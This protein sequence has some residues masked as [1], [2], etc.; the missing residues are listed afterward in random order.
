MFKKIIYGFLSLEIA[1][2]LIALIYCV[3]FDS[4]DL[5]LFILASTILLISS[6]CYLT[7]LLIKNKNIRFNQFAIYLAINIAITIL[8]LILIGITPVTISFA[9][10]ILVG[11]IF[12]LIINIIFLIIISTRKKFITKDYIKVD[13]HKQLHKNKK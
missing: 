1:V 11:N 8:N 7:F 3:F 12:A 6:F 2:K 4:Y 10:V 13:Y 9:Q 5:L